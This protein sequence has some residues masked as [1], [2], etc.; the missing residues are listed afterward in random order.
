MYGRK[1]LAGMVLVLA[2]GWAAGCADEV[3][4]SA[5]GMDQQAGLRVRTDAARNRVWVLDLNEVRVYDNVK[6]RTIRRL[7]L[8]N[9][10]VARYGCPPDLVLDATGS[11]IVSSNVV[12]KL[13]RIDGASFE[14][15]ELEIR[16][17][18]REGW[19]TGFG[20]LAFAAGGALLG[21]TSSAGSVWRIDIGGRSAR[22]IERETTH[23]DLCELT[24]PRVNE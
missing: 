7:A 5:Y 20:A 24:P 3:S 21:V 1:V 12:P 15:S 23:L 4:G 9:W 2:M 11:A 17:R 14:V 6:K 19:D 16:L 10:S 18:E 22:M 13:W 8:P